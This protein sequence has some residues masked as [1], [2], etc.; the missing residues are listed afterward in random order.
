[1]TSLT[2]VRL[3]APRAPGRL[4]PGWLVSYTG[5]IGAW[6][7]CLDPCLVLCLGSSHLPIAPDLQSAVELGKLAMLWLLGILS[8]AHQK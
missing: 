4:P 1:V 7:E 3:V 8:G 6:W 5:W 2:L